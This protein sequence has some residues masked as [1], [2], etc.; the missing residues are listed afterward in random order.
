MLILLCDTKSA[1]YF[2]HHN[3]IYKSSYCFF[4]GKEIA[5]IRNVLELDM[6]D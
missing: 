6:G 4:S 5:L 1:T 2:Q 3:Q